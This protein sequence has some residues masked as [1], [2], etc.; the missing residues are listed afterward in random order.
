MTK[1]E[2]SAKPAG[3]ARIVAREVLG[4]AWP[5]FQVCLPRCLPLALIAIGTGAMRASEAG[6]A[7]GNPA[8]GGEWWGV[9]LAST[10]LMLICYGA[11]LRQQLRLAAG[12]RAPLMQSL[13]DAVRD[14]P[15]VLVI[16]AAWILPLLPAMASTAWRG[17]DGVALV[18]ALA[19]AALLV[20]LIPAWPAMT[21][22]NLLPWVAL[23]ESIRLVRGR[24]LQFAGLVMI[25]LLGL[26]VFVLIAGI[27]LGMVMYLAGQGANPTPTA[28]AA[29]RWLMAIV[30][31]VPV[32]YVG[33]VSV[34]L[35][36]TATAVR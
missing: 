17:F 30:L 20:F 6:H 2:P 27:F 29:S 5:L 24:W 11:M 15:A 32:V 22:R 4:A 36:R 1:T 9:M 34:V 26:A 18:L 12:E 8:H 19:A 3:G 25:L 23:Q 21:A 35:W 7:G 31:A 10:V 28:L 16:A 14:V 33:A 13:S